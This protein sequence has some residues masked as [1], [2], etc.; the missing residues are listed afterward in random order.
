MQRCGYRRIA[1]DIALQIHLAS[2]EVRDRWHP[3]KQRVEEMETKI[4]YAG[5]TS[6]MA[7]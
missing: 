4:V 5:A 6:W 1:D 2:M 7:G 3:L